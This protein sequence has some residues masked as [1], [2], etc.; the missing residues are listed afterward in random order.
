MERLE[1]KPNKIGMLLKTLAEAVMDVV[2]GKARR[3]LFNYQ[4]ENLRRSKP[5]NGRV[6]L[7]HVFWQFSFDGGTAL[8]IELTNLVTLQFN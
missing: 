6:A 2:T 4:I 5:L 1:R 8:A 7:Y 3:E